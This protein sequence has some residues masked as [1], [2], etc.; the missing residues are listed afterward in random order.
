M[1]T[2][3]VGDHV[4]VIIYQDRVDRVIG[5]ASSQAVNRGSITVMS[6]AKAFAPVDTGRLRNSITRTQPAMVSGGLWTSV[7]YT[8]LEYGMYQEYGTRAHGPVRAKALRFKPKGSSKYVFAKWVRGV[9]AK[10]YMQRAFDSLRESDF[11]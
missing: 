11:F 1:G 2:F 9:P 3:T 5:A 7:V 4:N 8:D 10:R 6:R